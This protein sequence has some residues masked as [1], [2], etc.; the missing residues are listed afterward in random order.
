MRV[1]VCVNSFL[2][3]LGKL[4]YECRG[5]KSQVLFLAPGFLKFF[6]SNITFSPGSICFQQALITH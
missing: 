2:L 3:F 5:F 1:R 6:Y 4:D